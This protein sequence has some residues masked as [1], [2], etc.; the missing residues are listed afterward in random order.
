MKKYNSRVTF[1]FTFCFITTMIV[2]IESCKQS[3][4]QE[5]V[6]EEPTELPV[7]SE[8]AEALAAFTKGM[9]LLDV[10]NTQQARVHFTKAIELDSNFASAYIF[11]ASTSP[12]NEHF[13]SDLRSATNKIGEQQESEKI[14]IE[15]YRTF[16]NNNKEERLKQSQQLVTT[17]P[18]SARAIVIL[19]DA[20]FDINNHEE[21][22]VQYQKAIEL[23]PTW[24]GGYFSLG[25]SYMNVEPKD[26]KKAEENFLKVVELQPDLSGSHVYLGDAYRAAN[27]LE[28]ARLSYEK[29]LEK[30]P[31]DALTYLKKGHV[32]SYLGSFDAARDDYRKAAELN[33]DNKI[34]P[35][36]FEAFTYLYAGDFK[37]A[38]TWLEDKVKNIDKL[39][40]QES[41]KNGAKFT[42]LNNCA[43][44]ALHQDD[45]KEFTR[46]TGLM[47]PLSEKIGEGIGTDEAKLQQKAGTLLREAQALSMKNDYAGATAKA[48]EAK[49]AL[50]P[51]KDANKL[52][53]YH[54]VLSHIS[55]K[56][57]KFDDAIA[58]M[59]QSDPNAPY[60]KYRL[61][62]A[63]EKAGQSERANKIFNELVDYNFNNIGYALIRKELKD[64]MK[65]T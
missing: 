5:Q 50:E 34:A 47:K 22:R 31:S 60:A 64:K 53:Q 23:D 55:Y 59:E 35:I 41:Q 48:E 13:K 46:I 36:N 54:Y 25:T 4:K 7:T 10:G 21:A 28:N 62:M 29:A 14:L 42:F 32:N 65:T 58:H 57:G 16:L 15:I 12:S 61:A 43:V 26:F 38:K 27:D 11:R 24:V 20:Y 40:L 33:P 1:L 37:T 18:S 8:S 56:Q 45:A 2:T 9:D 63:C 51:I 44:I 17:Y 30:D 49:T 39:G 3:E 19:G 6:K 52:W